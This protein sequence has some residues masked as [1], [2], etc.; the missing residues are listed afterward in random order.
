MGL[1]QRQMRFTPQDAWEYQPLVSNDGLCVLVADARLDNRA[2]LLSGWKSES[3]DHVLAEQPHMLSGLQ[4]SVPELP[5]GALILHAYHTWGIDCVHHLV[6]VYA[7]ALWDARRQI[8]F[9]AR[10]P[11]VA[12]SLVY[13]ES[14]HS[15]AF[16]TTPSGLHALPTVPRTLDDAGLVRLLTGLGGDGATTIYRDIA[17]LPSGHRMLISNGSVRVDRYWQPDPD[18]EI[19]FRND[20]EY[21]E[22]FRHLF[23]RVVDD[24]L[25]SATPVALQMSG[26]LDSSAIAAVSARLLAD[27][28]E[29]LTTF[30]E[31]PRPGFEDKVFQWG[32][33]DETPLVQ[34]VAAMYPNIRKHLI[35]TDG[36]LFL[37]DL[38]RTFAHLEIPFYNTSNR[39]WIEAILAE[40]SSRGMKVLLDGTQGNITM[41]WPGHAWLAD[42]LYKR[43]LVRRSAEEMVALAR[44]RGLNEAV[45][46]VRAHAIAS[47]LPEHVAQFA[48]RLRRRS[49]PAQ[50]S[51][52][53][54]SPIHPALQPSTVCRTMKMTGVSAIAASP[55][56]VVSATRRWP[57]RME[58]PIYPPIA[59]STA[60][61]C[62]H[63]P[64]MCGLPSSPSLCP[65]INTGGDGEARSLMRRAMA[66]QLP[67]SILTNRKRGLQAA[68]WYERLMGARAEIDATLTHIEQNELA[69]RVLDLQRMRHLFERMPTVIEN[70][71]DYIAY[72]RFL[73][74]GLMIGAFLDWFERGN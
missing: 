31:V 27:R 30:T 42:L 12:P 5:D 16:A 33:A 4:S 17:Q 11:I 40:T 55:T 44:N 45:R 54:A 24:H 67:E 20:A 60:W 51:W 68:D 23:D 56:G 36:Q 58:A 26:G 65:R 32:Y 53:L 10:S 46:V 73:Q 13:T 66:G 15:F 22:A 48:R 39:V 47:L 25:S 28:G 69:Q 8:F 19:R 7:F 52:Q 6:G 43:Q 29:Q 59:P 41:S 57:R 3:Q 14:A 1:G 61:T 50:P 62:A 21:L 64:Q 38:D 63:P 70:G 74:G 35:H 72:L 37:T 34:A 9:A 2:E 49:Q 18:H 71:E